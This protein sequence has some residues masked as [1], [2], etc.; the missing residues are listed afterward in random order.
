MSREV[1]LSGPYEESAWKF[2]AFV[3]ATWLTT[4]DH[5]MF[6]LNIAFRNV[7]GIVL[8]T[9]TMIYMFF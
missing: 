2:F 7:A 6:S 8:T 9:S 1:T 4:C 3:V 5:W